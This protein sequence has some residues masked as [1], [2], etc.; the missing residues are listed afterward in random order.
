MFDNRFAEQ[1]SR[2]MQPSETLKMVL[3]SVSWLY[4]IK[5]RKNKR[6]VNTYKYISWFVTPNPIVSYWK[7]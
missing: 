6:K 1:K 5:K 2:K 4:D 3:V 7:I